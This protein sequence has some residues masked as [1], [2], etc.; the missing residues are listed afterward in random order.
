[1]LIGIE[2]AHAAKAQ[3]TG[4][5]ESAWQ[6]IQHLKNTLPTTVQ[7]VLYSHVPLT[8][9]LAQLPANW[10]VKV[11]RWPF[12]KLWSQVRLAWELWRNPPDVFFAPAQLLPW[13]APK[14]SIV[15]L[16]DSAFLVVPEAY[17][18]LS[19]WYLRLMNWWIMWRA[20]VV[21]TSTEFNRQ[22][23]LRWY[24]KQADRV[25]VI[26]LAYDAR[27]FFLA[28]RELF[29]VQKQKVLDRYGITKQFLIFVGRL[30]DKK[31]ITNIVRAFELVRDAVDLQLVLVG[32]PGVGF[33]NIEQVITK[34][35]HRSDII[36]PGWVEEKD[37][38]ILM[39]GADAFVFPSR[40]EGFGI[41]VLEA[42]AVGCPVVISRG[43][44]LPEV[45]GGAAEVV[46]MD[47]IADIAEHILRILP[48][49]PQRETAINQGLERVTSFSW[50]QTAVA[51]E[52]ELIRLSKQ[53]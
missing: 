47:D 53:G 48:G 46:D 16:H 44:A 20:A 50:K 1:M 40:Y 49:Q 35:A 10:S 18:V 41:P 27:N 26:P 33:D 5:E 12:S 28:T 51:L 7:V 25:R 8:G 22:E 31:N 14:K 17:G 24:G 43:T 4:V 45:A 23:L 15:F 19:Q 52:N 2:A 39:A 38:P 34:S 37:L 36:L 9:A 3:R 32:K 29:V 13:Y 30:E 21:V 42:M 6:I 11:L